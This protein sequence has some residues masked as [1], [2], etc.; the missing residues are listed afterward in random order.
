MAVKIINVYDKEK[1]HQMYN[2]LKMI[3]SFGSQYLLTQYGAFFQEGSVRL[4]SEYMD[5]GSI[6]TLINVLNWQ[7]QMNG[8]LVQIPLVP[9]RVIS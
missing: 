1:R 2:E 3:K 9:E 7:Q 5:C 8:S 6:E 4:I